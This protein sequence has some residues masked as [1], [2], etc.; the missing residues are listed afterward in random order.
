MTTS[1]IAQSKYSIITF[2]LPIWICTQTRTYVLHL[3]STRPAIYLVS[4]ES[5]TIKIYRWWHPKLPLTLNI[6][7]PNY[8]YIYILYINN[9]WIYKASVFYVLNSNIDRVTKNCLSCCCCYKNMPCHIGWNN[10][11][12][13]TSNYRLHQQTKFSS[14]SFT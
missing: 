9:I 13:S 12:K 1:S 8:I 2:Y 4:L 14:F 3:K 11:Q 6:S 10:T 5:H 7:T